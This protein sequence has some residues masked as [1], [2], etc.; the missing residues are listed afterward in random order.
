[1]RLSKIVR[2]V[3]VVALLGVCAPP[4]AAAQWTP[5]G[6]SLGGY[7]MTPGGAV[8]DGAG[9]VIVVW[10]DRRDG[11][12][13]NHYDVYAQRWSSA[14]VKMWG[15]NDAPVCT[16]ASSSSE[17]R[18][19][20]DG[21][22]GAIVVWF[23]GRTDGAGPGIYAQRV[24][25]SG[26]PMWTDQ[27]VFATAAGA[28]TG[29]ISAVSDGLGGV[30]I[31]WVDFRS[32]G[33]LVYAQRVISSGIPAWPGDRVVPD[34][35][36]EHYTPRILETGDG[37]AIIAWVT[38]P[39]SNRNVL[40]QRLDAAGVRIWN[41]GTATFV[42]TAPQSQSDLNLISDGAGGAIISWADR[43]A[44]DDIY[45][46]RLNSLGAAQWTNNG[47]PVC[48]H[49]YQQDSPQACPDGT[50]G[51]IF[52]WKDERDQGSGGGFSP[53]GKRLTEP[54]IYMQRLDGS[55]TAMWTED[56]RAITVE[57]G[58]Q[59]TGFITADGSGGA[60]ITWVDDADDDQNDDIRMQRYSST[61]IAMWMPGGV[62]QATGPGLRQ[63]FA[64]VQGGV[65]HTIPVWSTY[66]FPEKA[67]GTS[68][69]VQKVDDEDGE[70]ACGGA[71]GVED[72]RITGP[73]IVTAFAPNPSSGS[74]HLRVYLAQKSEVLVDVYNVRGQR[75]ASQ[76]VGESPEGWRTFHFDGQDLANGVYFYSVSAGGER[77]TRKI[78][79]QR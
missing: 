48:S 8:G 71:S 27:G 54:D 26:M 57:P 6:V 66:L 1:M 12:Y 10:E 50:G 24:N 68:I 2:M 14:G 63:V 32:G 35:A 7:E 74:G 3:F 59:R 65:G 5:G 46:Q 44:G 70:C 22:G 77:Q 60:V 15:F 37:G 39:S 73:L 29:N 62:V 16:L 79:I 38:G 30:V 47:V 28:Y 58:T 40:A 17:A 52:I 31:T 13:P 51:A 9:G 61:G 41:F 4:M 33:Q 42:C 78:V 11:P 75:V 45:A 19:V 43:R 20:I 76:R 21:S 23:D 34:F 53:E 72:T 55:G 69:F 49:S 56:G 36:A 67:E 25:S 18:V 64:Q